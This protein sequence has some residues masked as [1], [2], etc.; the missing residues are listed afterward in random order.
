MPRLFTGI[1]IPPHVAESL[2]MLRGGVP[3]ARWIDPAN[4]HMTLRFIGDVDNGIARD[5]L[6]ILGGVRRPAFEI[7]FNRLDQ[8][9]G[10]KPRA[11]YAAVGPN[12]ALLEL[13]ADLERLLQRIGLPPEQRKF[14]PHVTIARLRD[15]T[16]HQVADYLASLCSLFTHDIP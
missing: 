16:A 13:Q 9:G 4:Y 12:P 14:V 3:G 2:S 6:Q 5:V 15:S 7:L 10:R 1:E 11:V 8:F